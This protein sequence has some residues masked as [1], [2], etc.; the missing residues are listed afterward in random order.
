MK[1]VKVKKL[2]F[3]VVCTTL[4]VR[5][6][7]TEFHSCGI[8]LASVLMWAVREQRL[9]SADTDTMKFNIKLDVQELGGKFCLE[10]F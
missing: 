2:M 10:Y 6:M 4:S 5:K 9:Y 7:N 8:D 3:K 1:K